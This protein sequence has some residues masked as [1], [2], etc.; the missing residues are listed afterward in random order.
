MTVDWWRISDVITGSGTHTITLRWHMIDVPYDLD[1]TNQTVTLRTPAG[2]M[3]V[4]VEC[5]STD[6][7]RF[8]VRRGD[9]E[10]DNVQGFASPYYAHLDPIPTL[11]A[12]FRA[13][14]P[15]RIVTTVA[16][17]DAEGMG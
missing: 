3:R 7:L 10:P 15:I 6:A 8:V 14:C 11:E 4:G 16:V 1:E 5:P 13:L 12:E 2:V 17:P 9:E